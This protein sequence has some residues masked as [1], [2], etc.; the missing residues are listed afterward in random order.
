MTQ[1]LTDKQMTH[2]KKRYPRLAKYQEVKMNDDMS[3]NE[4]IKF[5][6]D[7]VPPQ[8]RDKAYVSAERD[9]EDWEGPWIEIRWNVDETVQEWEDRCT[10][11][12]RQEQEREKKNREKREEQDKK[13]WERLKA[14]FGEK[15]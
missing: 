8:Y 2:A 11:L 5:M 14:K 1:K 9:R 7:T 3:F 12:F 6:H 10:R 15:E 13:E 4:F